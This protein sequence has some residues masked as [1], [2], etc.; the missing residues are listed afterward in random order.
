M[1]NV[2]FMAIY[3]YKCSNLSGSVGRIYSFVLAFA[4][5]SSVATWVIWKQ[6]PVLWALIV[7]IAQVLHIAK[8]YIFFIKNETEF[9]EYY[10]D[11]NTLYLEY[12]RLWY[13]FED[14]RADEETVRNRFNAL[15]EKE[16]QIVRSHKQTHC[17]KLK[18]LL[19]QA[20]AETDA[21]LK[22]NF[23]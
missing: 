18:W 12:E 11:F 20:Q 3:A 10:F 8:P 2:K 17:P 9:L 19:D 4:S 23:S 1:A 16:L 5:A 13:D 15:R 7:G 14:E 22:L 6:Y 21:A